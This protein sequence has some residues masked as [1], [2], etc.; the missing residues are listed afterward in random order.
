MNVTNITN[1]NSGTLPASVTSYLVQ[2]KQIQ[3]TYVSS[4]S[5]IFAS[6]WAVPPA[7]YNIP[8]NSSSNFNFFVNSTLI[9]P[10]AITSFV[11]NQNNTSTL[12]INAATL[13]FGFDSQDTIYAI[14]KFA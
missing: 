12:T 2:T 13:G 10:G 14:G 11:D 3:G 5:V 6:G 4:N 1:N 9:D 7:G 8:N